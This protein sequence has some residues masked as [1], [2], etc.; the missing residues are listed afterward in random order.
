MIL[1]IR[2]TAR[3]EEALEDICRTY[4]GPLYAYVRRLPEGREPE[5]AKDLV[6]GFIQRLL[7]RDDFVRLAPEKGKLR[8]FLL[9]ALRNHIIKQAQHDRAQKRGSGRA[10]V[11][12]DVELAERLCGPD[13]A[14]GV[15]PEIAYDRNWGRTL[16]AQAMQRLGEEYRAMRKQALFEELSA[17]LD[18]AAAGDYEAVGVKLGMKANAVGVAV[19]RMKKRLRELVLA[20]AEE[21]VGDR[22]EAEAEVGELMTL[23]AGR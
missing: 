19:F 2:D 4:W 16:L 17:C 14:E 1:Q 12:I 9:T 11:A 23:L 15:R 13:L 6:Q 22:V 21:T 3:R 20:E 10:T 8:T 7:E 18:G 5:D